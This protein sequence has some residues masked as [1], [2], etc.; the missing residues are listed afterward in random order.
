APNYGVPLLA[1][2]LRQ[3]PR[4]GTAI[5]FK[6]LDGPGQASASI[7]L[8]HSAR[9]AVPCDRNWHPR[10]REVR[11]RPKLG[12]AA[13]AESTRSSLSATGP[14]RD[15]NDDA[16]TLRKTLATSDVVKL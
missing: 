2:W 6:P 9:Q 1:C 10:I 3:R 14:S 16:R 15:L 5:G 7:H 11:R 4:N 8:P 12:V 13:A